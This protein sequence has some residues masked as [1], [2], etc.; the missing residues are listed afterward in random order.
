MHFVFLHESIVL[1]LGCF[2][3]QGLEGGFNHVLLM[4][5]HFSIC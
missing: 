4:N 2:V 5:P 3:A 1:P